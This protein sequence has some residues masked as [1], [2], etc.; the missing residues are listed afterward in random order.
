M[1]AQGVPIKRSKNV[2]IDRLELYCPIQISEP[3]LSNIPR[4]DFNGLQRELIFKPT[5]IFF[6]YAIN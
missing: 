4:E 5:D 1:N 3:F 6:I 2:I